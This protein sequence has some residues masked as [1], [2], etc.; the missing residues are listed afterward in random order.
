MIPLSVKLPDSKPAFR[1]YPLMICPCGQRLGGVISDI[2]DRKSV[3]FS[4]VVVTVVGVVKTV[5]AGVVGVVRGCCVVVGCCSCRKVIIVSL[6]VVGCS[7]F[8]KLLEVSGCMRLVVRAV[9][10]VV[11]VV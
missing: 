10:I 6:L 8:T 5:V 3:V 9:Y 2:R 4:D 1:V 11:G 7:T